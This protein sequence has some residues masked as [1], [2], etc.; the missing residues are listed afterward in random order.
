MTQLGY[1]RYAA[2][3]GDWGSSITQ[4]LAAI[5][6]TQVIGIYLST[7]ATRMP[8]GVTPDQLS[9]SD[10]A[11]LADFAKYEANMSGYMKQQATR[12]QTLAYALN[13]SPLG[14]LA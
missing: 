10:R 1:T 3:G 5:D 14:Q 4:M 7:C 6:R 2:A 9:E 8:S 11:R 13:D 12:P